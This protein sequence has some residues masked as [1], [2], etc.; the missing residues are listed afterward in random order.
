ML[1][2]QKL[3]EN[4]V[5]MSPISSVGSLWIKVATNILTREVQFVVRDL[6]STVYFESLDNAISEYNERLK[7]V[8]GWSVKNG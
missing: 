7:V 3:E 1:T 8:L 5:V 2:I 6:D 4:P